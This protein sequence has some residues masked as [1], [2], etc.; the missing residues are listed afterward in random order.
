MFKIL[1]ILLLV[2]LAIFLIYKNFL[3]ENL[4]KAQIQISGQKFNVEIANNPITR[5]RGLSGR[6]SLGENQGMLFIFDSPG[7]HGFWMKDMK[8]AIDIIW[9]KNNKIIGF[10]ENVGPQIGAK[11]WELKIYYPPEPVDKVLEIPAGGVQKYG[12]KIGHEISIFEILT[13]K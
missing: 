4:Q 2:P 9:I 3:T 13:F 6:E 5:A 10:E 7:N 1:L 12:F 8:F 11:E